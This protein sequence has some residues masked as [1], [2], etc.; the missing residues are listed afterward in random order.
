M[1]VLLY[2]VKEKQNPNNFEGIRLV[3]NLDRPSAQRIK[4][5]EVEAARSPKQMEERYGTSKV[6][7]IGKT[8][9]LAGCGRPTPVS[10]VFW[11]STT[12]FNLGANQ[13]LGSVKCSNHLGQ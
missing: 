8:R 7:M 9:L 2:G 10:D 5:L 12:I 13:P 1:G 11:T 6:K 4:E 3:Q